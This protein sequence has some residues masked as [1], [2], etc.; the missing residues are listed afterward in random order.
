[1]GEKIIIFIMG[2]IFGAFFNSIGEDFW[3]F[4]KKAFNYIKEYVILFIKVRKIYNEY[5]KLKISN[6]K[7][8]EQVKRYNMHY[9]EW[10]REYYINQIREN[11]GDELC[12]PEILREKWLDSNNNWNM[13]IK[14]N[15]KIYD[16]NSIGLDTL[17]K[18]I[19]KSVG[20]LEM[21]D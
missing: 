21:Y 16:I 20:K 10:C 9:E 18:N 4:L 5:K 19:W 1:M 3:K 6:Q 14:Y 12:T 17:N 7:Y 13:I 2:A 15:G 8:K 11:Y